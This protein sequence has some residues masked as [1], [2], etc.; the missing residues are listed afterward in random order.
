MSLRHQLLAVG[1]VTLVLPLAGVRYVREVEQV[2]RTELELGLS[3]RAA[4]VAAALS[5]QPA[6]RARLAAGAGGVR[7]AD[8]WCRDGDAAKTI[9][10]QPLR[11]RPQVDAIRPAL[12]RVWRLPERN[13]EDFYAETAIEI[14]RG[15]FLLAGIHRDGRYGEELYL[16]IKVDDPAADGGRVYQSLLG[17][18]NGDRIVVSTLDTSGELRS[19]LFATGAPGPFRAQAAGQGYTATQEF[20]NR[21]DANW[22]E[23]AGG[24][25]VEVRMS[26]GAFAAGDRLGVAVIDVDEL[27][28][29]RQPAEGCT[30]ADGYA[31]CLAATWDI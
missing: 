15:H 14:G 31:V 18:P 1:V 27:Q 28:Q 16:A 12:E 22:Q 24:Y 30:A 2:L 6:V 19:L 13:A 10:A 11:A 21:V 3:A 4:R 29:G 17:R 20:D 25:V 5:Q 9:Y 7:C 26:L 8:A 23:I